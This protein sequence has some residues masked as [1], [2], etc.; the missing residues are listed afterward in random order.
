MSHGKAI[1]VPKEPITRAGLGAPSGVYPPINPGYG[2]S[3]VGGHSGGHFHTLGNVFKYSHCPEEVY[4][5]SRAAEAAFTFAGNGVPSSGA[6]NGNYGNAY[7]GNCYCRSFAQIPSWH[8]ASCKFLG[9]WK[10]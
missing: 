10:K 5:D 3:A 4:M 9:T 7:G 1:R 8:Q 2:H 6:P